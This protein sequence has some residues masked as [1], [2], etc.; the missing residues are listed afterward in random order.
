MVLLNFIRGL[1]SKVSEQ[2]KNYLSRT[3]SHLWEQRHSFRYPN[4]SFPGGPGSSGCHHSN[5]F[6]GKTCHVLGWD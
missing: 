3:L 4:L 1:G 6:K 2:R 5:A